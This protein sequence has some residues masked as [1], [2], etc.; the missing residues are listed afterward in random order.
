[1]QPQTV[2]IQA[3]L[4]QRDADLEERGRLLLKTKVSA[5]HLVS[6]LCSDTSTELLTIMHESAAVLVSFIVML[7]VAI[8]QLQQ[9]L[10]AS[11]KEEEV[12]KEEARKVHCVCS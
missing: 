2:D 3:L 1:M 8:E 10:S 5:D 7:Q 6:V 12:F 9:E 11:R 4:R